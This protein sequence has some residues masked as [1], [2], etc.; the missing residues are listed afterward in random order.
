MAPAS[1]HVLIIP[2][3]VAALP[4]DGVFVLGPQICII[5]AVECTAQAQYLQIGLQAEGKQVT[6]ADPGMFSGTVI[7]LQIDPDLDTLGREGYHLQITPAGML[8]EALKPAGILYGIQSFRQLL[9]AAST[10]VEDGEQCIP[11]IDIHDYPRFAWRGF[12]LDEGRHFHGKETVKDLLDIMVLHKLNVFHWHL[13]EDQGWRIEIKKYPRLTEMGSLRKGTA[14]GYLGKSDGIA[15][16][17]YYTQADIREIVAY[18]AKLNIMIV[19]EIDMPGHSLAALAAYPELSCTGGPFEVADRFGIFRDIFCAGSEEV[20]RFIQN[21]L[22]EVMDLF[23][24]DFIHIGGDEAPRQRW[25]RCAACQQCIQREGLRGEHALQVYFTN[26]IGAY[27]KE[28]GRRLIGWNEILNAELL[29]ESVVQYWFRKRKE[30]VQAVRNNRDVV[31][32]SYLDMYLDHSYSLTPLSRAYHFEP[33]FKELGKENPHILGLEAPLWTEHVPD[34]A[35]MDYQVFPRLTAFAETGWTPR[36]QKNYTNFL[37]RL[38][39]FNRL[40]TA[41]GVRLP[42]QAQ[43]EPAWWRRLFGLFTILQV[44]RAVGPASASSE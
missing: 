37:H 7:R 38:E 26:R 12:M 34:R 27:L 33:V 3:P 17:G 11:A 9:A 42:S 44:Q 43:V 24:G 6:L 35:R 22:D 4:G 8:I 10:G 5:A 15:H 14:S 2:R 23:P 40:L 20:F 30:V 36:A 31:V 19:P 16:G 18:A 28:H 13:T 29:K 32:S 39:G 21:V 1:N 25:R 41:L